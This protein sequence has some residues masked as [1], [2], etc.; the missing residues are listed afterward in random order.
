MY[1]ID[2]INTRSN[3]VDLICHFSKIEDLL[4]ELSSSRKGLGFYEC[5][6]VYKV[7]NLSKTVV[8]ET[9][10]IEDLELLKYCKCGDIFFHTASCSSCCD[11][12]IKS[13]TNSYNHAR[14]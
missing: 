13:I 14:K 4:K 6:Y 1:Q 8:L 10:F 3:S 12:K 11:G 2:F 9:P 7:Y 5:P